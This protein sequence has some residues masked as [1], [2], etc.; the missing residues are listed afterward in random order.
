MEAREQDEASKRATR[1]RRGRSLGQRMLDGA[2]TG[3]LRSPLHGLVS[4]RLLL[5]TVTGRVTGATYTYPVGYAEDRGVLL[6]GTATRWRRNLGDGARVRIRWKGRELAARAEVITDEANAAPL[7][8]IILRENPVHGRFAGIGL[9]PD[10]GPNPDDL[11]RA[12]RRGTAVVRLQ[13]E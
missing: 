1:R 6:I 8:R 3:L 4:P 11:R 10:G 12:L 2:M 5:I 9:D 13:P 7:Y